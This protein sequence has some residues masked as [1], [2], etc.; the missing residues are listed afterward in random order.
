[1]DR[2]SIQD[3]VRTVVA[4]Y[5][6]R[7][8]YLYGS[9]ARGDQ[10]DD[11]DIDLRFLCGSNIDFGQLYDIQKELESRLGK[12]VDIATAPPSQMRKSFY[13]R[14]KRDEVMLYAAV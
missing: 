12:P 11:S 6:V 4:P 2:S 8:A 1:M 3:A 13:N 5:D 10:T 9:Y 7:E 14:I